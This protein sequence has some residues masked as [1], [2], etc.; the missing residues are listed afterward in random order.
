MERLTYLLG[1]SAQTKKDLLFCLYYTK[2]M[3]LFSCVNVG[4]FVFL[5][6]F[7]SNNAVDRS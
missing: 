1:P 3:V 2:A 6:C 7:D 4:I 5:F